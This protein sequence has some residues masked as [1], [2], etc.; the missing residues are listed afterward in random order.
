MTC[1]Q[2]DLK[3][4]LVLF[5]SLASLQLL[6]RQRPLQEIDQ[7]IEKRFDIVPSRLLDAHMRIQRQKS[8]NSRE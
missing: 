2:F 7:N 6:P 3:Y 4:L 8:S 5:I 1:H